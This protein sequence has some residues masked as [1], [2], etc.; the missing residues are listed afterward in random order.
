MKLKLLTGPR[1]GEEVPLDTERALTVGREA[2]CALSLD[3]AK[4]SRRHCVLAWDGAAW[5]LRDEGSANGTWVDGEKVTSRRMRHGETV[6]VGDTAFE[7]VDESPAA[8]DAR[9]EP[10]PLG[11]PAPVAFAHRAWEVRSASTRGGVEDGG[12]LGRKLAVAVLAVLAALGIAVALLVWFPVPRRG[13][14]DETAERV[15]SAE[16]TP[17]LSGAAPASTK[18]E[19]RVS[20]PRESPAAEAAGRPA[21]PRRAPSP[22]EEEVRELVATTLPDLVK[23]HEYKR[24]LSLIDFHERA[25]PEFAAS[26]GDAGGPAHERA[27]VLAA[28]REFLAEMERLASA[29]KR[30]EGRDLAIA[31]LSVFPRE[32][33]EEL[34]F[35]IDRLADGSTRL[36]DE[37][38][39]RREFEEDVTA[40]VLRALAALEFE[41]AKKAAGDARKAEGALTLPA[42]RVEAL[43]ELVRDAES[44]WAAVEEVLPAVGK[45]GERI[46]LDLSQGREVIVRRR[47]GDLDA[48][49]APEKGSFALL[50]HAGGLLDVAADGSRDRERQG[51]RVYCD[52]FALADDWLLR[53]AR[54]AEGKRDESSEER[55]V[56]GLALLLFLREG[57]QRLA[58]F[59]ER[60][61]LS[62]PRRERVE[63]LASEH[64]DF[65]LEARLAHARRLEGF[66][67]T[68]VTSSADEWLRLGA[69]VAELGR[70]VRGRE[71]LDG[72]A[73]DAARL[74]RK[75]RVE[76]LRREPPQGSFRAAKV[77]WRGD[78]LVL[79]YDFS[80][81]AQL[82]DLNAAGAGG[83]KSR[84]ADGLELTGEWRLF[85]D[86][87]F[88]GRLKVRLR[89]PSGGYDA[90]QP[91]LSV[92]LW[93]RPGDVVTAS[94]SMALTVSLQP[95]PEQFADYLVFGFGYH[96]AS[97]DFG[98]T[99]LYEVRPL[100][101]PEAVKLPANAV[102]LGEHGRSLHEIPGECLWAQRMKKEAS[103]AL[104]LE[105]DAGEGV[106]SWKVNRRPILEAAPAHLRRYLEQG[107]RAGS[108]SLVTNGRRVTLR[109]LE[110]EGR[111][112]P[113]W[114]AEKYERQIDA[115]VR[116]LFERAR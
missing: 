58:R 27:K 64:A 51:E 39:S 95:E 26:A 107:A 57:P 22:A 89:L 115:E 69:R 90:E 54:R 105:L 81:D 70:L 101:A 25:T 5:V 40:S 80:S 87:P 102:F 18:T 1:R 72:V 55:R 63:A 41:A 85:A 34:N 50:G 16:R 12:G 28:A 52:V 77:E 92:A 112:D 49:A 109:S 73:E 82:A 88:L 3:D 104:A 33:A 99:P 66:L 7:V 4:V 108:V 111:L 9:G 78:M 84:T 2:S 48:A 60:A 96:A 44:A 30:G 100:G 68:S 42:E 83:S 79:A 56:A 91:N 53:C 62:P 94:K 37:K 8:V 17:A 14:E 67:S 21:R 110:I 59:L 19:A 13:G 31:R 10:L 97:Y 6:T 71:N 15:K 38:R 24:A 43:E 35:A 93:T 32:L 45:R 36:S 113:L 103:G 116:R 11:V 61:D 98:G 114:L 47:C 65:W 75:V 74:Y 20:V 29:G 86:N 76:H 23:A 106:V 46:A